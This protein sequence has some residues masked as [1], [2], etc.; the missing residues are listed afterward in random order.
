M[1]DETGL[2][3]IFSLV[4]EQFRFVQFHLCESNSDKAHIA[5]LLA[6][7]TTSLPRFVP[8]QMVQHSSHWNQEATNHRAFFAIT[9]LRLAL[10]LEFL[11][12]CQRKH[13]STPRWWFLAWGGQRT[14]MQ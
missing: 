9:L 13:S 1:V 11:L 10:W 5:L 8:Y 14:L 2:A 6:T 3:R 7:W 12:N 4:T